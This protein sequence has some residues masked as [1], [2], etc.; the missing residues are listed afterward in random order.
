M[1]QL[2]IAGAAGRMGRCVLELASRD[3]R[4]EIAAA[5]TRSDDPIDGS[6]IK[7]A[8]ASIELTQRI[9][10]P[11]D[12]LIDFTVGS[13]TVAWI[14]VCRLRGIPMVI[15]ATGHSPRDLER[16]REAARSIPIVKAANFSLGIE[17]IRSVLAR[18]AQELGEDYDVEIVEIHH[19]YKVDAPSGTALTFA[20]EV[21]A[22]RGWSREHNVIYGRQVAEDKRGSKQ[23]GIHSLRMGGNISDH[24]VH[25]S[26]A[27]ETVTL[28][29]RAH[30][31][32]PYA[33]GALRAAAWVVAK[34]PSLYSML[35]VL[36][37][38]NP[39]SHS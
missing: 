5:L 24:E 30:S 2:A 26:G 21:L 22:A 3:P 35:D 23:I 19:R 8:D 7:V 12:V 15:G 32:E 4:F 33:V 13:G 25:F 20:D 27:G 17:T 39:T 34:K 29:H 10:G 38:A 6:A 37:T 1:I 36:A 11:C 18:L 16:I 14:D 31:R 28:R 9:E